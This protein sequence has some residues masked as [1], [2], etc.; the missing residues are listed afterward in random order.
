MARLIVC[1]DGTWITEDHEDQ[2]RSAP[3][4]VF[5]MYTC[6]EEND[7][8]K[9][10]YH[11]GVGTEGAQLYKF[12]GGIYGN[13][14]GEN[15]I[16][17]Y[18]WLGRNFCPGDS[19]YL[20]GFSRGAFTVR[21]LAGM[22]G[23]CGLLD[24]SSFSH[25]QM[26][27]VVADLYDRKYRKN[28][29]YDGEADWQWHKTPDT[30][31]VTFLGVWDTVGA[32]GIPD[33]L[34]LLNLVDNEKNWQFHDLKL[35]DHIRCARHAVAI[36][37]QRASFTPSLWEYDTAQ[38]H[39]MQQKWFIGTH[40]DVGG[41]HAQSGLSDIAL[42]WMIDEARGK[43][44]TFDNKFTEQLNPD[45][46]GEIHN[47]VQGVWKKLRTRPRQIPLMD[48]A[49]A[50]AQFFHP[51]VF[52]RQQK[53]PLA[54][55]VYHPTIRLQKDEEHTITVYARKKW[56]DT[57]VYLEKNARYEC[58]AQG[59]WLD[60]SIPCGPEGIT[61]KNFSLTAF[62]HGASTL[63][64]K[65]ENAFKNISKNK[66][67]DF[68]G[69]KRIE[70]CNWFSLVGAIAN[71]CGKTGADHPHDGSPNPHKY[72]Y[73]G[74]NSGAIEITKG[75]YLYCFPNDAWHFYGNNRGSVTV[76]VKRVL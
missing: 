50:D 17:A 13:G 35:G 29:D 1:C 24:T 58:S 14:L 25:E 56:N 61:D 31:E 4:N 75:G 62:M 40:G 67:A 41:G 66:N 47:S 60:K 12:T 16:G 57:G 48:R 70:S 46:R 74:K 26:Y 5:K 54:D 3:S 18:S 11:P 36:D 76:A 38:N 44:L 20:F 34:S 71:A 23:S 63:L 2:K 9:K 39:D 43:G 8:Q 27:K 42:K 32:L 73:I 72:F 22:L 45:P 55:P 64:G 28:E 30:I 52:D 15:I 53:P 21:S 65:L 37:E 33:D 51:T 69:T 7:A 10:Y 49:G 59:Q 6:I 19:I 68:V